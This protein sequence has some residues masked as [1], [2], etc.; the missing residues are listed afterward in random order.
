MERLAPFV[1]EEPRRIRWTT[2]LGTN[3][4]NGRRRGD[5]PLFVTNDHL[6]DS[7]LNVLRGDRII[8]VIY[9]RDVEVLRLFFASGRWMS[10]FRPA[11]RIVGRRGVSERDLDGQE[12][13]DVW[14]SADWA[15]VHLS[16]GCWVEVD[17]REE[18]LCSAG[19][20]LYLRDA[21]GGW[22]WD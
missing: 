18:T 16:L 9:D 14:I 3:S 6:S 2:R 7:P 17:L 5:D 11:Y 19:P 4:C 13:R 1:S 22:A 21:H 15:R 8:R 10:T 12:V 20:R